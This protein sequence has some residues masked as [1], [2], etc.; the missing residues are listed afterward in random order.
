MAARVSLITGASKG[1]GRATAERLAARGEQVI[2][3]ARS[4][5][6]DGFPGEFVACD[7]ADRDATAAALADITGRHQV[8]GLFNNVGLVKPQPIGEVDLDDM[9]AVYDLTLRASVQV[10]QAVI[11]AMKAANRG[12]IVNMSSLTIL[13]VPG[14]TSYGS[15]KAAIATM[16]RTWALELAP[17]NITVNAIAPGP[18]E[19]DLFRGG[20][21]KGSEG[22]ARY[23]SLVPMGRLGSPDEVGALVAFLMGDDA[24]WITGQIIHIDGGASVGKATF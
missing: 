9:A 12:R 17:D 22:E 19:T 18:V 11:P 5:P 16:T 15:S 14:R 8:T 13:G 7:L 1:I 2:G 6:S 23:L 3:M 4:A 24:G 20:N 10:T 21:P